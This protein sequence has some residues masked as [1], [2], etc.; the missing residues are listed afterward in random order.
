MAAQ[1]TSTDCDKL[2]ANQ[3]L[4]MISSQGDFITKLGFGHDGSGD[5]K[6]FL[7]PPS[8]P[9][10]V[11]WFTVSLSWT[12]G[13]KSLIFLFFGYV[14][15]VNFL[16]QIDVFLNSLASVRI[17]RRTS[18]FCSRKILLVWT[19]ADYIKGFV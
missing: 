2:T 14:N 10:G 3:W 8:Q 4:P 12:C 5:S 7:Y 16:V 17:L 15:F 1:A 9:I 13:S 6:I 11:S 19:V 18:A